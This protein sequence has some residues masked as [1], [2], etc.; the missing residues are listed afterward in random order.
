MTHPRYAATQESLNAHPVPEW[1]HDAKFGVFIHWGLFSVPGFAPNGHFADVIRTDYDRAMLVHPYAEDYWNAI[2]DPT[3][4]SAAFHRA[5]YGE[6]PYQGLKEHFFE[7][8]EQWEPAA[9]AETFHNA[10]AGYV[11]LTAKYHDGFCLW[12]TSV[13]NP[14]EADWFTE[15]DIVGELAEAVRERGMRFGV[16]YSGGVDWTFRRRISRTLA[17]YE[18][19]TP[20]G[21]YPA[22][23]D[24]H[25]RELIDRYRPDI[26]WN[27][28]AWPTDLDTLF[29]LFADY[30]NAVPEGVVNDRWKHATFLSRLLGTK[31]ARVGFDAVLKGLVK[32]RPETFDGIT[33]PEIPHSDFRTPEYTRFTDVQAKKWEMTRGIGNSFGYNRNERDEDYAD[34]EALLSD[35]VDAVAKNGN[36]LLNVRPRGEDAQIP[37]EQVS[38]LRAFGSW[39]GENGAAVYGTGPFSRAEGVTE[40]GMPVR[41]TQQAGAVNMVFLGR[42]QGHRLTVKDLSITGEA[43]LLSDGSPVSLRPEGDDLVLE[44]AVPLRGG[45][46]PAV[47][48]SSGT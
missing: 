6:M 8:L 15:R 9:W 37:Q 38:R 46:A 17:D 41:F 23:A 35:F 4:P 16:Y 22:Y 40:D 30:Y 26:L 48:V 1:F 42:P 10:G 12:P 28:I 29:R 3:T 34:S 27:D 5:H 43:R 31:P 14:H 36:L 21:A 39:L 18:G 24:A 47:T 2:K 25:V 13:T 44:F 32:R 20:G 45:Y 11:V 33:P 7:G 19:S